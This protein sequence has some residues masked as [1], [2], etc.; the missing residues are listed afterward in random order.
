M[1]SNILIKLNN[2]MKNYKDISLSEDDLKMLSKILKFYNNEIVPID[3]I[4]DKLNLNYEQVNN[5]LIYFAKERIVKLNYKVWCE[6]SNCNSEQSIYENIYE[7]PLEECDMC[8]KK[9]K[10]VNNI[11]VVYR[12]KLDE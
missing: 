3:V 4:K 6:N 2:L 12:V 11:Y 9:C 5:L 1:L 10:K 8:P 7:I